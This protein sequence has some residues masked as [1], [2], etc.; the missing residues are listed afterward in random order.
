MLCYY[1][2]I[3][4]FLIYTTQNKMVFLKIIL[5]ILLVYYLLKETWDKYDG[6][7]KE[8]E[9]KLSFEPWQ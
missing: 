2:G 3:I 5:I 8:A 9:G 4:V 6:H 7:G 1:N